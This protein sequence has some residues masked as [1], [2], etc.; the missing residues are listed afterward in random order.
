MGDHGVC[1]GMVKIIVNG[2]MAE[3]F[4]VLKDTELCYYLKKTDPVNS[5]KYTLCLI[6]LIPPGSNIQTKIC[7]SFDFDP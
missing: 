3:R 4:F 7:C 1:N 2:S 5:L 6:T